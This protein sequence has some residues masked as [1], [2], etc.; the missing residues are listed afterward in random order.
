MHNCACKINNHR[1]LHNLFSVNMHTRGLP[2]ELQ[3]RK[4]LAD[5][6]AGAIED[7]EKRLA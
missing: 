3:A 2:F 6:L 4:V 5:I 1:L 7:I